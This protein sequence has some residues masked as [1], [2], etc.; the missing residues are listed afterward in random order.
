MSS[1]PLGKTRPTR[2]RKGLWCRKEEEEE[3][4]EQVKRPCMGGLCGRW[5]ARSQAPSSPHR[6]DQSQGSRRE[7]SAVA[8]GEV[9]DQLRLILWRKL[10]P[11]MY[12][13]RPPPSPS[14]TLQQAS[15]LLR[16]IQVLKRLVSQRRSPHCTS[17]LVLFRC[18]I[19]CVGRNNF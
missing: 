16:G 17:W 11:S 12:I 5:S 8:H 6:E 13:N 14:R 4:W 15:C 10:A 1:K 9:T 3:E 19:S 18:G 2:I 7:A